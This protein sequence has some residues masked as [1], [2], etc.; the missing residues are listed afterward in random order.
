MYLHGKIVIIYLLALT[1]CLE[2]F[3]PKKEKEEEDKT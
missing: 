2:A 1:L 3:N